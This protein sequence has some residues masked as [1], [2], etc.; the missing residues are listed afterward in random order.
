[1]TMQQN[2]DPSRRGVLRSMI[3]GSMLFPGLMSQLLAEETAVNS[4][5]PLAPRPTHFPAKA[6]RIIL[7][8]MSGGVSHVDSWD[9]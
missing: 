5:D 4:D 2:D 1:M 6:K 3:G 8:H 7:L 9:P